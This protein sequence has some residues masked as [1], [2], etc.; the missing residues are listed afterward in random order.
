MA[1]K[2]VLLKRAMPGATAIQVFEGEDEYGILVPDDIFRRV[3]GLDP[4]V[5]FSGHEK[6]FAK[7]NL[8]LMPDASVVQIPYT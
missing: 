4:S 5:L 1:T 7:L 3:F 6:V 8:E 2:T